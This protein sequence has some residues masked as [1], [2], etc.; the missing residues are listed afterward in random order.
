M[1]GPLNVP[2]SPQGHPVVV[3]A[4]SSEAGKELAAR[5]A[6][7]V[8]TAQQTLPEA[9]AFY[10]DLKG[11]LAG[12]GRRPEEL[13]VMPGV[14]PVVGRSEQR[15]RA[16]SSRRCSTCLHPEV[17]LALLAGYAGRLD[18]SSYPL[19]GPLPDLPETE[20]SKSRQH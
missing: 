19:D 6:E 17:G 18:L 14:F 5:T 15:G 9:Q 2:R 8:F 20:G 13:L 11:R 3:Q 7:V 10:A 4:G 1:R 12:Y 16:R